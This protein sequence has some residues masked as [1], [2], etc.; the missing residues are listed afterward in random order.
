MIDGKSMSNKIQV[1]KKSGLDMFDIFVLIAFSYNSVMVYFSAVFARLPI[2]NVI[3]YEILPLVVSFFA[4]ICFIAGYFKNVR[5]SDVLFIIVF[6]LTILLSYMLHPETNEYYTQSNLRQIYVEAIPFFLLAVCFRCNQ[7]TLK[8]LTYISFVAIILNVLYMFLFVGLTSE[9]GEYYMGQAYILLPHVMFAINSIFDQTVICKR[10]ISISFSLLGIFFLLAM[11]TRGPLLIAIVYLTIKIFLSINK[12]KPKTIVMFTAVAI[13]LIWI[14]ASD[15]Y[16]ILFEKLSNTL[17]RYGMSTRI[18]DM[19]L[20]NEY[21]S[22]TSGRDK[23][24]ELLLEKIS[25]KPILGYGIWGEEQFGVLAHNIALE[26]I[27]YYGIPIGVTIIIAYIV[28]ALRAYFKTDNK[29]ARDFILLFFVMTVARAPFG[30]SHLSYY[31]FFLLGLS[32]LTLRQ[33]KVC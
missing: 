8:N 26:I 11:G 1:N 31:F 19:L 10:I 3:G 23:I 28:T 17:S 4:I 27:M 20:E 16:L 5:I 15:Y 30:G 21:L 6:V 29:Y 22:H 32:I 7:K 25:E 24:Y 18:I 13:V 9:D 14:I 12:R 33:Q 2:I